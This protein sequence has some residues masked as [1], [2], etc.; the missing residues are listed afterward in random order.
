MDYDDIINLEHPTSR[1]HKRMEIIS[2]AAQFASFA[3]L[4][5]L[6][7]E[8]DETAR[9][10]EIRHELTDDEK[11][12]L[13]MKIQILKSIIHKR[14]FIKVIHFVPDNKKSGGSYHTFS[15]NIRRI[16]DAER[17]LIF[18]NNKIIFIDDIISINLPN[19]MTNNL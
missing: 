3:A 1:K 14:P 10:T 13:N 6:D 4:T 18:E 12:S 11:N 7:D 19:D 2:R 9:L 8:A 15:G 17:I 5:G 16:E